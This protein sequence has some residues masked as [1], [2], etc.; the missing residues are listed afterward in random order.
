VSAG[1]ESDS[2]QNTTAH[3]DAL[4]EGNTGIRVN[5]AA[6]A[7]Q[8]ERANRLMFRLHKPT[9]RN[10]N[11]V[12][13]SEILLLRRMLEY[14]DQGTTALSPSGPERDD[15]DEARRVVL[16]QRSAAEALLAKLLEIEERLK[17]QI[18]LRDAN[19]AYVSAREKAEAIAATIERTRDGVVAAATQR[20]SFSAKRRKAEELAAAARSDA[21]RT[22][23]AVAELEELLRQA[24][25]LL[26]QAQ[27]TI[28]ERDA[29]SREC[30]AAERDAVAREMQAREVLAK[31]EAELAAAHLE[32]LELKGRAE[33]LRSDLLSDDAAPRFSQVTELARQIA[34]RAHTAFK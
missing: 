14:L 16:E 21:A 26:S 23:D 5:L 24:Q 15:V 28:L 25:Q 13:G 20:Q 30:S 3:E 12:G 29:R 34:D 17:L 6:L 7:S 18:G 33:A 11:A 19:A 4:D 32:T 2:W 31:R 10:E 1:E 9:A 22:A 8:R 27:A